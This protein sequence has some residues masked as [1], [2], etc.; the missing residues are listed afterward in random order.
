MS[1]N[2]RVSIIVFLEK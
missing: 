2:P 1:Q